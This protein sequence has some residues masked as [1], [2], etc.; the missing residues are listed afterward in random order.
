MRGND[1]LNEVKLKNYLDCDF[2]DPAEDTKAR[3]LLGADFGSL[4]PVG[5]AKDIKIVAD[6]DVDG[7]VNA[8]VGANENGYHYTTTDG[9][10][11]IHE[12]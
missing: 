12:R 5:V 6:L 11:L 7:M 9:Y 1:E 10:V 3:E 8:N 2:L 4:G